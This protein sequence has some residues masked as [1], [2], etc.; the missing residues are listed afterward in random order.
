[1]AANFRIPERDQLFLIPPS[2]QEWMP[3]D[4]I[5][6]FVIEAA[7]LVPMDDFH[8]SDHGGGKLQYHPH[9]ML[10]LLLYC[11]SHGLFALNRHLWA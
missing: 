7:E 3:K 6:H 9:M 10:A 4:D 11:Y 2:L 1:M 5:V 8:I